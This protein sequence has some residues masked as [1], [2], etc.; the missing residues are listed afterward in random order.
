MPTFMTALVAEATEVFSADYWRKAFAENFGKSEPEAV[1]LCDQ[2]FF[3]LMGWREHAF[4]ATTIVKNPAAFTR[5]AKLKVFFTGEALERH[6][7]AE[8]N[9]VSKTNQYPA[10]PI[11]L[12][13]KVGE[14]VGAILMGRIQKLGAVH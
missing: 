8:G 13:M 9:V 11:Q 12:S 5:P 14:A 4:L 3:K 1:Q 2:A 10:A 7:D 6:K